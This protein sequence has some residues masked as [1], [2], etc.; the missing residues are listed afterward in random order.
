MALRRKFYQ[1]K[2]FRALLV[3]GA[4]LLCLFF[5]PTFLMNPL[6]GMLAT[7]SWPLEGLFSAVAFEVRDTLH[8]LSSIG[9]LKSENERLEKKNTELLAEN[10]KWQS[11]SRENEEL[12]KQIGLLPREKFDLQAG[13]VIGRDAAGVGNWIT[14]NQGSF[15]GI[16]KGMP[17]I[18][19]GEVLIGRVIEVYPKSAKVMLLSNP[20]SRVSGITVTGSA[21]GIALG[22]HGLGILFDMV[23]QAETLKDGDRL[24]TSGLGGEF[25][26][27]L[28]IGTLQQVRL[29][30]DRL[31]QRASVV[32]PVNFDALRYVFIIKNTH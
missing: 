19:D 8:F 12:R 32:S 13:E 23:L 3:S 14:V 25:P 9:D 31:Y 30:E 5:Q 10:S 1:T 26:K 7:V 6:R 24:V 15:Q 17:V 27:D 21:Q 18:V 2:L 28:F 11:I 16:E 22:E 29:S 20:E 4:I